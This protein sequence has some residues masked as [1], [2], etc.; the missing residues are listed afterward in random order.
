MLEALE[1]LK[2]HN[3][4]EVPFYFYVYKR[5]TVSIKIGVLQ[6]KGLILR[7][8]PPDGTLFSPPPPTVLKHQM[9]IGFY[10]NKYIIPPQRG[11]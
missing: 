6:G 3:F 1:Q 7:V 11:S 4:S 8:E 2:A 10:F 9:N 5:G